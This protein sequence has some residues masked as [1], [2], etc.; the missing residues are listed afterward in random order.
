MVR[1][2]VSHCLDVPADRDL[3]RAHG[4]GEVLRGNRPT[5]A[6][7]IEDPLAAFDDEHGCSLSPASKLIKF[8]HA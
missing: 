4:G 5:G 7:E 1:A 6:G 2:G 8:D 3:G